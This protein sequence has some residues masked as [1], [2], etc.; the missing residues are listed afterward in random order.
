VAQLIPARRRSA[1]P[2]ARRLARGGIGG[3]GRE[4]A[5][6]KDAD[7]PWGVGVWARPRRAARR[8]SWIASG[9]L[10]GSSAW[11]HSNEQKVFGGMETR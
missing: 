4:G 1:G 8:T 3:S 2:L 10:V 5:R 6:F 7:G 9:G 11:V